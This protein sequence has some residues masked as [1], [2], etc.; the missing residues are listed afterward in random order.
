MALRQF[1]QEGNLKWISLLMWAGA[2]P[3]SRG[4]ALD[5]VAHIDDPEWHATAFRLVWKVL[6]PRALGG[7]RQT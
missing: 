4:P 6:T 5:D 1:C 7:A 2:N 3:Q